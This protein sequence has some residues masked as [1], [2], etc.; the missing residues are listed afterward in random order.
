[1]PAGYDL[2]IEE[3][4]KRHPDLVKGQEWRGNHALYKYLCPLHGEYLQEFNGHMRTRKSGYVSGCRECGHYH[5]ALLR[6]S[7]FEH[8]LFTFAC[9]HKT[10]LPAYEESTG[11]A[12][13]SRIGKSWG[14]T[15][16]RRKWSRVSRNGTGR[17]GILGRMR[18][19]LRCCKAAALKGNFA[20]PIVTSE[21]LVTCWYNQK[22]RCEWTGEEI[23]LLGRF[24]ALEHNHKTGEFRGFVKADANH[25]EG[26]LGQLSFSGRVKF[27]TRMYP[28]EINAAF[29]KIKGLT[30]ATYACKKEERGRDHDRG[31]AGKYLSKSVANAKKKP[32][33]R[34]H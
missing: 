3:A 32:H 8:K 18:F 13:W 28:E 31:R 21:E 14:C 22:G 2:N 29:E 30:Y 17:L 34:K 19:L 26:A 33:S 5:V 20:A 24:T 25:A 9:G 10:I 4:Q 27:F 11:E 7:Q 1:M 23:E 6:R 12:K 15:R 16:C